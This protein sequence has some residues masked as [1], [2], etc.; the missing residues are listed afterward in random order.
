MLER[1]DWRR[2]RR[3]LD[4]VKPTTSRCENASWAFIGIF[5]TSIALLVTIP[6]ND[7]RKE[8]WILAWT[9]LLSSLIF[10]VSFALLASWQKK[11]TENSIDQVKEEMDFFEDRFLFSDDENDD[12]ENQ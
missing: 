6:P 5:F 1:R 8:V 12:A 11:N 3:L 4:K 10:S 7:E 2:I 9:M